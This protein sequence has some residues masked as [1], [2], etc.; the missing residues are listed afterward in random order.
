M[1][2]PV[3]LAKYDNSWFRSGAGPFKNA[4]WY[5]LGRP[6]LRAA[7]MTSSA[8]RV[9][10]LRWFGAAIGHGVVIKPSFDVKYPWHLTIG[11]HCWLGEHVWIDN[12]ATVTLASNVCVSQGAYL[13]TGNHDW[14]DPH[15]GLRV[16]PVVLGEGSWVGAKAILTPGSRLGVCSVA[17]AGAL[18]SGTVPDFEIYAGNPARL[19]RVRVFR[20]DSG[21]AHASFLD[22]GH[23]EPLLQGRS[24]NSRS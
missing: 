11:D 6:L 24:T 16:D 7:W 14:S 8:V 17:A 12:L 3:Q 2:S 4:A 10:L 19:I 9:Y 22:L 15:F 23:D 20:S 13:C 1:K 18:I 5:F 21:I